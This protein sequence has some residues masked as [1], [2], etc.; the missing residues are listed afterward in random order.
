[1]FYS[2]YLLQNT[3]NIWVYYLELCSFSWRLLLFTARHSRCAK[4]RIQS[5]ILGRCWAPFYRSSP[6]TIAQKLLVRTLGASTVWRYIWLDFIACWQNT[7]IQL[8]SPNTGIISNLYDV[9]GYIFLNYLQ[10]ECCFVLSKW[11]FS[12][13]CM[14]QILKIR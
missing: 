14:F 11:M 13:Q 2:W 6:R 4:C 1:M 3:I 8:N 12:N 5:S 7:S 10:E 9:A